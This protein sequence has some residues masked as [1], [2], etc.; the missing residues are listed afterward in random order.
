[1]RGEASGW[2]FP[3]FYCYYVTA[4]EFLW[5]FKL[6]WMTEPESKCKF[7]FFWMAESDYNY[8]FKSKVKRFKTN[9]PWIYL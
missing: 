2:R 1:M 9:V 7:K 3:F 5:K 6:L 8:R 4:Q